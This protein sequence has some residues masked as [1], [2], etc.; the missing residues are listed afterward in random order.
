MIRRA[1]P[2]RWA[3][4]HET[5]MSSFT[6]LHSPAYTNWRPNCLAYNPD[7]DTIM[8]L[9]FTRCLDSSHDA[10]LEA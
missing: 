3:F 7:T 9:E 5:P 4:K 8:L 1:A 2:L 10:L 6:L